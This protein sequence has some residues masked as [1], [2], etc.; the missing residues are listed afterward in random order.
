MGMIDITNVI[1]VGV[2]VAPTGLAAY[3]INNLACFTKDTPVVALTD[4]YA[5][6]SSPS[7][8]AAQWGSTSLTYKAALAVFSQS[9][10]II[11]GGGLFIVVPMLTTPSTETLEDAI[12][13]AMTLFYFGGCSYAFTLGGTEAIDSAAVCEASGKLFFI[14]TATQADLV[15]PTGLFYSIKD[16][17]YQHTRTLYHT[18]SDELNDFRWGYAGR[19]MSTNF[20]GVATASTMNLKTLAGVAS[21]ID[22]TQ[23]QLTA[24][25]AVGADVYVNIAGQSCVLSH[26]ANGFFDDIYNLDWIV[27]ALEVAGFNFLRQ[28]GTKIPQTEKGMDGLKSAYRRVLVQAVSNGFLSAGEWT[29][30]DTFGKP[31]D[32]KRNISDFGYFIYSLPLTEQSVADREAR[33]APVCQVA[34]KYSGAIH[35]SS[36]IVNFNK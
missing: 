18:D 9:P 17:S 32:F 3:N 36:V 27:G 19:A 29:G 33:K 35:S 10:N 14:S 15:G 11:S 25:A 4:T 16:E 21:D 7:E 12:T 23:S 8:V 34:L 5:V 20:S 30:S 6:Y 28:T 13:R 1:N 24:A 2:S 22:M 31:E 26:G